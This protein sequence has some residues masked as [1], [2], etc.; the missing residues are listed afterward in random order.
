MGLGAMEPD[1]PDLPDRRG[2][3]YHGEEE[4]KARE[5]DSELPPLPSHECLDYLKRVQAFQVKMIAIRV[6]PEKAVATPPLR[7]EW[8][9]LF[10][11]SLPAR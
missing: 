7:F 5:E 3:R 1:L 6:W 11:F 2:G 10:F 8:R 9:S 4:E